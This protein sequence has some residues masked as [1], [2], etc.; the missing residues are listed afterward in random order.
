METTNFTKKGFWY[1]IYRLS[2]KQELPADTCTYKR[3]IIIALLTAILLSPITLLRL[4]FRLL[5]TI[6]YIKNETD[7]KPVYGLTGYVPGMLLINAP[8]IFGNLAVDGLSF[9]LT[10]LLGAGIL[11]SI[12]VVFFGTFLGFTIIQERIDEYK[13]ERNER[14]I[15]TIETP[16]NHQ[17]LYES[18][19]DKLCKKINWIDE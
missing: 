14:K 6:P 1:F 7:W 15:N 11:I 8:I 5:L 16:S 4:V 9:W 18:W 17:N 2:Y 3:G 13:L 10:W 19:K 12:M